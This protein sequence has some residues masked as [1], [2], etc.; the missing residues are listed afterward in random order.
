[1]RRTGPPANRR[2]GTTVRRFLP[3]PRCPARGPPPRGRPVP[4]PAGD[5]RDHVTGGGGPLTTEPVESTA[6]G[7]SCAARPPAP[8]PCA[9]HVRRTPFHGCGGDAWESDGGSTSMRSG[10]EER[11]AVAVTPPPRTASAVP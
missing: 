11:G 7:L 2:P 6:R 10:G 5:A 9:T 3:P 8:R 4:G 1:R